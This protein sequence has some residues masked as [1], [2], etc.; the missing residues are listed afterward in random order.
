[1]ARSKRIPG[2][3]MFRPA[4][5]AEI[6][7]I[8]RLNGDWAE[9]LFAG[10]CHDP[11]AAVDAVPHGLRRP[12]AL[13]DAE[14]P[15]H[16]SIV[17]ETRRSIVGLVTTYPARAAV[18]PSPALR[19]E[20]LAAFLEMTPANSLHICSLAVVPRHRRR[21]IAS[22][23]LAIAE[24][25]ARALKLPRLSVTIF[26]K[27]A[28]AHAFFEAAG[29]RRALATRTPAEK[30]QRALGDIVVLEKPIDP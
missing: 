5:P 17:A 11:D 22:R 30:A 8:E 16:R 1:M 27:A 14:C 2:N 13:I 26:E 3:V 23:L 29:F 7:C 18:R 12:L 9:G 28:P 21:G 25:E 6:S 19:H 10:H 15:H 4:S 24:I 20:A